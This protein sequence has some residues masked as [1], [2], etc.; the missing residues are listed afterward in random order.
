VAAKQSAP[1]A[2]GT[3]NPN[4]SVDD[5]LDALDA[6]GRNLRE[7]VADVSLTESDE[8]TG[9]D[10]VRTG[11]VWYQKLKDDDRIR[12]TFDQKLEGRFAKDDKVEYL[13]SRGWLWDRNY[14]RSVEV[15]RQVLKPG[16]KVNLLKL[17]EGPFPLPIGQ[18]KEDVKQMFEVEIVPAASDDP[19][20][21]VHGRLTPKTKTQFERKF[22]SIDVWVDPKAQMPRRIQTLDRSASTVQTTDLENVK[23]NTGLKDDDFKLDEVKAKDGWK[24]RDE[25]YEE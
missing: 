15:K 13:L 19:A 7:F 24:L 8:A 4:S 14:A 16:E 3:L 17:G 18:A 22:K 21:T 23:S 10:S 5:V 11:H 12:V 2:G 6:R 1:Q 9:F 20:G 25:P